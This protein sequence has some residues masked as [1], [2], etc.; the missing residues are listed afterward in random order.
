MDSLHRIGVFVS[1]AGVHHRYCRKRSLF[2][3][4][5][6]GTC[7]GAEINARPR[8]KGVIVVRRSKGGK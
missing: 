7:P 2:C 1:V 3:A 8:K 6:S 4:K 5:S